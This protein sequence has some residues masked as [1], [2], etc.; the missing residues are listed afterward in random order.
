MAGSGL[1]GTPLRL[2]VRAGT[3]STT[4]L[5]TKSRAGVGA[6]ANWLSDTIK[7]S[8]CVGQSRRGRNYVAP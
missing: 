7:V 8:E 5:T 4:V 3:Y 2:R 1:Y 6:L